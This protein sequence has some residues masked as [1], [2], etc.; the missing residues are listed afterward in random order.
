MYRGF[1]KKCQQ[2]QKWRSKKELLRKGRQKRFAFGFFVLNGS[3][4]KM[5]LPFHTKNV[6]TEFFYSL[7]LKKRRKNAKQNAAEIF[8]VMRR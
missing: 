6:K 8:S 3:N 1:E 5:L 2:W 7:N 4:V